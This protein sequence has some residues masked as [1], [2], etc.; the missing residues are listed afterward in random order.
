MTIN[1]QV[2]L[3][4]LQEIIFAS[5]ESRNVNNRTPKVGR[6]WLTYAEQ[7]HPIGFKIAENDDIYVNLVFSPIDSCSTGYEGWSFSFY[8]KRNM[9][10]NYITKRY[11]M[12]MLT[13]EQLQS[14]FNTEVLHCKWTKSPIEMCIPKTHSVY[15]IELEYKLPIAK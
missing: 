6:K 3:Q 4:S 12:S 10:S 13:L 14:Y 1:D 11:G 9:P 2:Q 7:K 15:S 8:N 5:V